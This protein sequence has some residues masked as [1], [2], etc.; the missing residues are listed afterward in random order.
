VITRDKSH[1]GSSLDKLLDGFA[2]SFTKRIRETNG[3]KKSKLAL[4]VTATILCL[5][6]IVCLLRRFEFVTI[7]VTVSDGESL[8]AGGL[9]LR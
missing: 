2:D 6:V 5:K 4:D 9:F 1:I 3:G 8:K 7:E